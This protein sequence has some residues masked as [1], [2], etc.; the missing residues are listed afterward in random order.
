MQGEGRSILFP[1]ATPFA[2]GSVLS[3]LVTENG[4]TRTLEVGMAYGL[5]TLFLCEALR[6]NGGGQHIAIDPAQTTGWHSIGLLNVQRAGLSSYLRF[7]EE[8]SHGAL[9]KLVDEGQR[10]DFAFID[11]SHL[12][13]RTLID[14]YFID[15][16]LRTGGYVVFDDLWMPAVRDVVSYVVTNRAYS[17]V[18]VVTADS[19]ARRVASVLRRI[20]QRP[21]S[22]HPAQLTFCT[23]NIYVL[24]KE[25]D[26]ERKWD[27]HKSFA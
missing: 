22:G 23:S 17:R 12:F 2:V 6:S 3:K 27:F 13:D 10:L 9:A 18:P 5:S 26:D 1:R 21:F 14:F 24:R 16:M 7:M 25:R 8:F 19:P 15:L 20:V 4:F 11:G